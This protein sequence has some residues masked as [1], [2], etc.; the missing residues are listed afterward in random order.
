MLTGA[1]FLIL[2]EPTNHLDIS[3]QENLEKVLTDFSGTILLVSHDRYFVDAL[4]SHTWALEPD[5]K[6]VTV[7]K[8]GYSRYLA[9]R[10][11]AQGSA[12]NNTAEHSPKKAHVFENKAGPKNGPPKRNRVR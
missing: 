9:I 8:G 7:V 2:D 3:S 6:S 10:Q 1:N 4:A 5:S 12:S 11:E